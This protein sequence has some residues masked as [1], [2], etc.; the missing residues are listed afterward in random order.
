M[1]KSQKV[2]EFIITLLL[3]SNIYLYVYNIIDFPLY[4]INQV[5]LSTFDLLIPH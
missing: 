2:N 5:L 1:Y 3:L 4:Y